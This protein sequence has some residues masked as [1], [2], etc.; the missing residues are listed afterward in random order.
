MEQEI[1]ECSICGGKVVGH[2]GPWWGITPPPPARCTSCGAV[3]RRGPV[4]P[5]RR[6]GGYFK[7][8][9]SSTD[10]KINVRDLRGYST[11]P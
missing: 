4:I 1:G 7:T 8:N 6:D 9:E 2:S 10:V 11:I 5:M 3:E